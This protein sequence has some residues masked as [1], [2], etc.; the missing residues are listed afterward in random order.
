MTI[1][2]APGY[3]YFVKLEEAATHSPVLGF[4]IHGGSTVTANVPLGRLELKYATSR[5]GGGRVY[6]VKLDRRID[7]SERREPT[8]K[9]D[10][11]E[12]ILSSR[13]K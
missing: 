3:N 8:Y 11:P 9:Q 4:F 13:A 5:V 10:K 1:R 12:R 6:D 2:T 7:P